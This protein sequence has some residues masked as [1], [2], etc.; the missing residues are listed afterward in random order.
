MISDAAYAGIRFFLP[1][2][3]LTHS[4]GGTF[5]ATTSAEPVFG[6]VI[7]LDGATDFPDTLDLSSP[8]VLGHG[9]LT[10]P[11]GSAA[12]VSIPLVLALEPGWYAILFGSGQFGAT[13]HTGWDYG[14][15]HGEQPDAALY[16]FAAPDDV[17]GAWGWQNL[18]DYARRNGEPLASRAF[19]VGEVVPLPAAAWLLGS[20]LAVLACARRRAM[21]RR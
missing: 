6:A 8:D 17:S 4:F 16:F 5:G 19:L 1:E 18:D 21:H 14:V 2:P 7:A 11:S 3:V 12:D 15:T 9:L 20:A 10:P 13:G